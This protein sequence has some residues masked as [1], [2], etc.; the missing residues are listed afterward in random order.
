MIIKTTLSSAAIRLDTA[1][2]V[3]LYAA[4]THFAYLQNENS[5]F[6]IGPIIQDKDFIVRGNDGGT[7]IDGLTIDFSEAANVTVDS[8]NLLFRYS[9][10]VYSSSWK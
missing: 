2:N 10:K 9:R 3:N 5:D 4:G 7:Y 8:G 1:Q 6:R